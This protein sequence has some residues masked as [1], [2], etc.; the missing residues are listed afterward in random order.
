MT[1]P[2]DDYDWVDLPH[3]LEEDIPAY[4]THAR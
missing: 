1:S 4:P 3:T 2:F